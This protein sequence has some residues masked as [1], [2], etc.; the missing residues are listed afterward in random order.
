MDVEE[1]DGRAACPGVLELVAVVTA[2]FAAAGLP[3]IEGRLEV[4]RLV[5][6]VL[7]VVGLESVLARGEAVVVAE[8]GFLA[9]AVVEVV[10]EPAGLAGLAVVDEVL[11]GAMDCRR[12][13]PPIV[14]VL[15]SLSETDGR[16]LCVAVVV[17]PVAPGVVGFFTVP[18]G[19]LVGG[20]LRPLTGFV[21]EVVAVLDAAAA[22]VAGRRTPAVAEDVPTLAFGDATT[23]GLEPFGALFLGVALGE[24][25]APVP[26]VS[27]PDK[28]DSS[29]LTTSKLSDSDMVNEAV[30]I[31][32][33]FPSLV[34]SG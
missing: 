5:G 3:A 18:A 6:V 20:C 17:V 19:G 34:V 30:G 16:D 22:V 33:S 24:A 31:W 26:A 23:G 10:D 28:M 8:A 13:A 4:V 29:R 25:V 15:F 32:S 2:G 9:A 14:V 12:A 7:E 11:P 21:A 1:V 27:S